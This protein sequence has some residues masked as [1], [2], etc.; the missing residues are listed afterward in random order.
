MEKET[1][2]LDQQHDIATPTLESS[3]ASGASMPPPPFQLQAGGGNSGDQSGNNDQNGP[4]SQN[5]SGHAVV[6]C[7]IE[8]NVPSQLRQLMLRVVQ[9]AGADEATAR[10][11]EGLSEEAISAA[12][13]AAIG[14]EEAEAAQRAERPLNSRVTH[15]Y[16]HVQWDRPGYAEDSP[17]EWSGHNIN[18]VETEEEQQ[19]DTLREVFDRH[20]ETELARQFGTAVSHVLVLATR[21]LAEQHGHPDIAERIRQLLFI[22][23]QHAVILS[24]NPSQSERYLPDRL[25]PESDGS[26][27]YCNT[28]VM[29][30]LRAFGVSRRELPEMKA[31]LMAEHIHDR[32][33]ARNWHR[34]DNPHEAQERANSG[35]LVIILAEGDG[36]TAG[37]VSLVTAEDPIAG[38]LAHREAQEDGTEVVTNPLE[39]NAGGGRAFVDDEEGHRPSAN[40]RFQ[41]RA[42][43]NEADSDAQIRDA[44]WWNHGHHNYGFYE[45]IG[46]L[47]HHDEPSSRSGHPATDELGSADSMGVA[48]GL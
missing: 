8:E 12:F 39:S 26:Q 14:Q 38:R 4:E 2:P 30:V 45:Y 35:H 6:Q 43:I 11:V 28:Y 10:F 19:P 40:W 23:T 37:H 44:Q 27:T 46:P 24:L 20:R 7:F 21:H 41:N 3:S 25:N 22:A 9:R 1:N 31:N 18:P 33:Y 16:N 34:Y 13:T 5:V 15:R 29:D 42:D 47:E 48:T 17:G 36:D 32:R